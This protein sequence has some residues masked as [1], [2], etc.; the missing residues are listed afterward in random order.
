[1]LRT[2]YSSSQIQLALRARRAPARRAVAVEPR[3]HRLGRHH[4]GLH[5]G[6]A[7]LDLR[8]VEK[9]GGVADQR[10]A[11]K[12]EPRDR[13]EAAFVERPRAIGDAP[14]ALEKRPDRRVRLEALEL[15]ERVQERVPVVEPDDEPDRH[16]VVFQVV[17]KRA[18]IGV[19][20]ERP[21]DRVHDEAGLVLRRAR[22]PTI[23]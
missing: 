16:L 14:P 8:H 23:P 21:A 13:L 18:A 11:G 20:V 7:A 17:E 6:V 9:P 15:L 19:A 2:R 4:A 3:E 22:P 12:I 10:A 1:M 5:R